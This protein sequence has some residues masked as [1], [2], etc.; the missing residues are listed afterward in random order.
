M[1]AEKIYMFVLNI[2][3]TDFCVKIDHKSGKSC[4]FMRHT[5]GYQ[6]GAK[7]TRD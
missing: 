6:H 4:T 7:A 1:V 3:A 2:G 5:R